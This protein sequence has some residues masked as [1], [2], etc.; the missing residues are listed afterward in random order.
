[1]LAGI[2]FTV[3]DSVAK[4]NTKIIFKRNDNLFIKETILC[5]A[6]GA[7]ITPPPL[8][9]DFFLENKGEG[10]LSLILNSAGQIKLY[11]LEISM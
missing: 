10:F 5:L 7:Q 1:M 3:R 11:Q 8:S 2:Q 9:F 6:L 4:I